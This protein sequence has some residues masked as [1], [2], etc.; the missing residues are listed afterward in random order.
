[1]VLFF[2]NSIFG[3]FFVGFV[4]EKTVDR[5][6]LY[7]APII[8]QRSFFILLAV[9]L[10]IVP[11]PSYGLEVLLSWD[12][13]TEEEL[14]GYYL[15]SGTSSRT[16]KETPLMLP[17]ESLT[18][19]N[20]R[21]SYQVPLTVSEGVTYYFAVTA[22]DKSG[23]ETDF[24]NEVQYLSQ[25]GGTDTT[26]PVGSIVINNGDSVTSSL[27]TILTL[28]A[29]D[30]D[31][32]LNSNALMTFSNDRIEWST[33]EPYTSTKIWTLAPGAGE[34]TVYVKFCDAAGNW[35]PEPAEDKIIYEESQNTNIPPIGTIII[36]GN[37]Y[38]TDSLTV[39]L[40][41]LAIDE[42]RELD[43]KGLMTF[44]ND[45]QEWST[46]EPYMTGKIWTLSSGVGEKTV[47]VKFC[48]A[49]GNWM[50]EPAHD[51]IYYEESEI[52]CDDPQK[53]QP[54]SAE[55]SGEFSRFYS[56]DNVFDENPLTVWSAL[57]WIRRDQFITLDLGDIKML[58]G[59]NM[60][61]SRMFGMDFFPTDF[62]IQISRDNITWADLGAEWGYTPPLQPPYSD[63]W[64]F[65]GIDCR[66]IRINITKSRNLLLF[67]HLAQ[68]A[69]IEVY[70]C[71]VEDDIPITAEKGYTVSTSQ[72][73]S[74][75]ILRDVPISA[76]PGKPT[77]PGRPEV[78]FE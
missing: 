28:S 64:D 76:S 36:N 74:N 53:L 45:G 39:F 1:L 35:M 27:D 10:T 13:N 16:Y 55:A 43:E 59:L 72:E 56:K 7:F 22:Y 3:F 6:P 71:N 47:Y 30:N 38:F 34:K 61:A 26:P 37:D 23:Y 75:R 20:G 41:L 18:E 2:V 4:V 63:R 48:D 66:Y 42:G 67:F 46:P 65:E 73:K 29:A 44:S 51:S 8:M 68:I 12:Q 50:T 58:S 9:L 62:Q 57:S 19:V 60:Y 69:E 52:T 5:N 32:A 33:P 77:T 21:V 15:Y 54:V 14:A 70:G 49:A 17:K 31:K 78:K 24:S 11:L 25:G 40:T